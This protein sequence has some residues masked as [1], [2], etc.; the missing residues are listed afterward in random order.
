MVL[1]NTL[2][3]EG[4]GVD[5]SWLTAGISSIVSGI[6]VTRCGGVHLRRHANGEKLKSD[7]APT[8]LSKYSFNGNAEREKENLEVTIPFLFLIANHWIALSLQGH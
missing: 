6:L 2:H 3:I 7:A 8:N 1:K 4:A 5:G